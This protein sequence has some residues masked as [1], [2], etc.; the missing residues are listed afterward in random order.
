MGY[1]A[2]G[3]GHFA[4]LSLLTALGTGLYLQCIYADPGGWS[5]CAITVGAVC[6]CC[7]SIPAHDFRARPSI[8]AAAVFLPTIPAGRVPPG[9]QPDAE[10]QQAVQQVKRRGGGARYCKKCA[11]YKPPRTHHCRRCGCC[12][13]RMDHH[14]VSCSCSGHAGL[15]QLACPLR[16]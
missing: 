4:V 1:S 11:A 9:W 12:V 3:V 7:T 13:L 15:F 5:M 6:A 14:C 16:S 10:K 2:D 8:A